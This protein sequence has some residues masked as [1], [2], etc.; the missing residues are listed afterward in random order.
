MNAV[1]C[2]AI[3]RKIALYCDIKICTMKFL[4]KKKKKI[5]VRGNAR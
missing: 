4:F 3:R 1:E 5:S 2:L